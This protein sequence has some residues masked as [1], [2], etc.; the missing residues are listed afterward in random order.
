MIRSKGDCIVQFK[1]IMIRFS[2]VLCIAACEPL[3]VTTGTDQP[4]TSVPS[5]TS[6][7]QQ[8]SYCHETDTYG[9]PIAIVCPPDQTPEF[10]ASL[11]RAFAARRLYSGDISGTGPP[12]QCA[13]CAI[14]NLRAR[15][16]HNPRRSRWPRNWGYCPSTDHKKTPDQS[17]GFC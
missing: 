12:P 4:Q 5:P 10:I 14:F 11:Q 9:R 15:S 8:R 17:G 7:N 2:M 1:K 13:V 6:Q 16:P 3:P